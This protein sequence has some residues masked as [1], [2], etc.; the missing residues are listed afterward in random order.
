MHQALR[1]LSVRF[2]SAPRCK[3]AAWSCGL[4]RSDAKRII[5]MIIATG[6]S[7]NALPGRLYRLPYHTRAPTFQHCRQRYG[8]PLY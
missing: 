6:D 2:V 8:N 4:Y 1:S 3:A 5:L 7:T